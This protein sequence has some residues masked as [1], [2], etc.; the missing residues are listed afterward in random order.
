MSVDLF[1]GRQPIVDRSQRVVAYELL[2]R[3]GD[4]N[5]A[6]FD[7]RDLASS[8]VLVSTFMELGLEQIVG[9]QRA[10]INLTRPFLTGSIILP[11]SP[12]QVALEVSEDID[13]DAEVVAGLHRYRKDGFRIVLDNFAWRPGTEPLLALA[14]IVKLDVLA[15]PPEALEAYVRRLRARGLEVV[16]VRVETAEMFERCLALGCEYFQGYFICRP[17]V[18]RGRSLPADRARVVNLLA[19]I[20]DPALSLDELERLIVQDVTL[21]YRLLRYVNCATFARR[22]EINSM[23]EA[24]VLLGRRTIR[25]WASLM[26]YSGID[27]AKPP[28]L[29]KTGLIRARM[30]ERLAERIDG[31]NPATAFTAGL[32]STLDAMLDQPMEELLDSVPLSVNLKLA[33]LGGEGPLGELLARALDYER[34]QWDALR[35]R[36]VDVSVHTA[37]YLDAVRWAEEN[38]ELLRPL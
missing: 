10:F 27:T 32:F 9:S 16:A 13:P 8:Q 28:E 4:E 33:L 35:S 12:E 30:C 37:I 18:V 31:V 2:Y 15:L 24:I 26:L 19:H 17:N 25:D 22:R 7:D 38:G 36:G 29:L 23:Q 11:M 1:I 34:A 20:E 5:R 14:D 6:R 21:S 3:A